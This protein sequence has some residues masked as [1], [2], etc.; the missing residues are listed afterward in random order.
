M[1]GF[2]CFT[3]L[4]NLSDMM[5]KLV[6]LFNGI[7]FLKWFSSYWYKMIMV[8]SLISYFLYFVLTHLLLFCI[9]VFEL[10]CY[11]FYFFSWDT[12]ICPD[13]LLEMLTSNILSPCLPRCSIFPF[14]VCFS[15]V[16]F[17]G[18]TESWEFS[19]LECCW[20]ASKSYFW[21]L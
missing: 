20:E 15:N 4:K 11:A 10:L 19:K 2:I 1:F 5:T 6:T 21:C 13:L 12:S 7:Y 14:D 8:Y 17:G 16:E 3:S 9:Q 18:A